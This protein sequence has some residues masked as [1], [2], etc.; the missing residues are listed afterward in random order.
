MRFLTSTRKLADAVITALAVFFGLV[1]DP[2]RTPAPVRIP[3][4]APRRL[5]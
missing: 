2:T 4:E 1:P 3:V 5:R